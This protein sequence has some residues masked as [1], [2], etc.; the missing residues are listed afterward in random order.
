MREDGQGRFRSSY[1]CRLLDD[2]KDA[3]N[4]AADNVKGAA[5]DTKK[6]L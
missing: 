4:K 1:L 2:A 6:R 3:V 5:D